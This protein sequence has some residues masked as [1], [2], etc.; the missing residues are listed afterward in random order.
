MS[1]I[2]LFTQKIEQ[3]WLCLSIAFRFRPEFERW[4][5]EL[6]QS[7]GCTW[8]ENNKFFLNNQLRM[9]YICDR[10]AT[11]GSRLYSLHGLTTINKQS[12]FCLSSIKVI[13]S[14]DGNFLIEFIETHNHDE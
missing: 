8:I 7:S 14:G 1:S 12:T 6:E 2:N 4:K 13:E 10:P 9:T 5:G 11:N 3:I